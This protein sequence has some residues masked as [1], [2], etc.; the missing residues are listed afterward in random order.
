[1]KVILLVATLAIG[2]S[3]VGAQSPSPAVVPAASSLVNGAPSVPAS[4]PTSSGSA[5][6]L[7]RELK[8]A[9][10]EI[11]KRQTATLQQLD[12]MEKAAEQI[13]IYSKRG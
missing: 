5:L 10:D 13:K 9:N 1:M 12:E 11:L 3:V 4:A 2:L 6:K 7:I 8:A